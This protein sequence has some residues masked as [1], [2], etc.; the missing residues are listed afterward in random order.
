MARGF[1]LIELIVVIVVLAILS[2][3]AVTQYTD[4]STRARI[5]ALMRDLAAIKY[6]ARNY[7]MS[8][9]GS[10]SGV[11]ELESNAAFLTVVGDLPMDA[12]TLARSG[13]AF[14]QPRLYPQSGERVLFQVTVVR[15]EGAGEQS[16]PVMLALDRHLDD[17]S[18]SGGAIEFDEP[19]G[20]IEKWAVQALT[21]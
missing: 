13:Y 19:E 12:S 14:Q 3:V 8:H 1:T 20:P 7:T 10:L 4:Y 11:V 17:G 9:V 2:G 15:P 16:D 6:S 5:S 21:R 18:P